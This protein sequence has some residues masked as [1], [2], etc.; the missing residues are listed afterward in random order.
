MKLYNMNLSNF[1]T[2]CRIVIYEKGCPVEIAPIPGGDLK[3]PEYLMIYP[4]G[5]TPSLDADGMII[6]ESEV[7][8]E[9]LEEKF[10][11]K[12]LMPKTP[13]ARAK[14]RSFSR[15][16][17]LYLE[18]PGRAMFGQLDPKTRDT[19][20]VAEKLAELN[21]RLDQL[22]R[23]LSDGGYAADPDFTLAD[24]SL[25]PTMFFFASLLPV[26]GSKPVSEGR[27]RLARWWQLVQTRPTVK[28]AL[29]EMAEA[30]AEF[31]R[32]GR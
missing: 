3:S 15:F 14:V 30:L 26:L 11:T 23:M 2:R 4:M 9:Y 19:K 1:A 29:A 6:G 10:P 5:K 12:A 8:S 24:C 27:P 18:P 20:L 7:I 32:Q 31:Q 21:T 25:A 13:E 28:K 16:H 22:E 17:D